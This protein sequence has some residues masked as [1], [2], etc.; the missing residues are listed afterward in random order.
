MTSNE[1]WRRYLDAGAA[2]GQVTLAR[3]EEI[4]KGLMAP[5]KEERER[6]WRELDALGRTGRLV[7]GKLFDLARARLEPQIK[8]VRS[9][10]DLVERIADLVGWPDDHDATGP[11]TPP[12]T[13][14]AH[15][16]EEPD[17]P[18]AVSTPLP[19]KHKKEKKHKKKEKG[20]DPK[21][22]AVGAQH[23][24]RGKKHK[25]QREKEKGRSASSAETSEPGRRLTLARPSDPLSRS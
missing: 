19:K 8:T 3:A 23:P 10:D 9:F 2:V 13:E 1:S 12:A 20:K 14:P 11:G 16:L 5:G 21:A 17:P 25:K 4:A 22:P 18:R 6:A 7:G 15:R 24:S